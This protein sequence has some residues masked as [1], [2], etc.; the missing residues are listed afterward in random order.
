[1]NRI[2]SLLDDTGQAQLTFRQQCT[3]MAVR[4]FIAIVGVCE[5]FLLAGLFQ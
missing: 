4:G 5:L 1:M 2:L 3:L